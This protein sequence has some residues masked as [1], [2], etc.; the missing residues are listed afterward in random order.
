M[1]LLQTRAVFNVNCMQER[2]R[3]LGVSRPFGLSDHLR[4]QLKTMMFDAEQTEQHAEDDQCTDMNQ[5]DAQEP[6]ADQ[7]DKEAPVSAA[8]DQCGTELLAD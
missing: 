3:Q 6:D 8:A 4:T 1:A 5:D 2:L 7:D